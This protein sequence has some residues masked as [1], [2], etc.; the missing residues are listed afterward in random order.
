MHKMFGQD[1][2]S[3]R[4][5]NRAEMNSR[6]RLVHKRSQKGRNSVSPMEQDAPVSA[7]RDEIKI[8]VNT[9]AFLDT[10]RFDD[11]DAVR[12]PQDSIYSMG[13]ELAS[14]NTL[15]STSPTG[16]GLVRSA[17]PPDDDV[18][19]FSFQFSPPA[20]NDTVFSSSTE[21]STDSVRSM[22]ERLAVTTIFAKQVTVLMKRLTIGGSEK[23]PMPSPHRT[24]SDIATYR[25]G[26]PGPVPHPGLAVP[27]DFLVARRYV[28]PCHME[29]HF[30]RQL[31]ETSCTCWC[32]IADET[33]DDTHESFYITPDE[34]CCEYAAQFIRAGQASGVDHFGNTMLHLFA[35]L[36]TQSGIDTTLDLLETRQVNPVAVN[37][38]GQTFLHVLSAAWFAR[39]DDNA[40]PLYRVLSLLWEHRLFHALFMRDVYGRTF[41][42]QLDRFVDNVQDFR[43]VANHYTFGTIPRDAFGVL[44][45]TRP[46]E[47]SFPAPQRAGTTPLSPLVEED[48]TQDFDTTDQKLLRVLNEAYENHSVEDEQGRNGLQCLAE[49]R[50]DAPPSSS[51]TSPNPDRP[52]GG[53]GSKRKRGKD[54]ADKPK[55]IERRAQYLDGLLTPPPGQMLPDVNHYDKKGQ[56]VLMAFAVHL[57]DD[58]DKQGHH[59]AKIIDLLL[60]RGANIEARNR[61]GETAL[62][63]A[64]KHGNK[65]IVGK[66]LEKGANIHAR[67][68]KG[69]GIMGI[70]EWCIEQ[71]SRDLPSYG[72]LEAVRGMLAKKFEDTGAEDEPSL[73]HE[74]GQALKL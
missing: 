21:M 27:G 16:L 31:R 28:Q 54:D 72:R 47:F 23:H 37:Q 9:P 50:L 15:A 12:S 53:G 74:W 25:R 55:L 38:A 10:P 32:T 66:L 58:Q 35:A 7:F 4:P 59:V 70:L 46:G 60:D 11:L 68:V 56:T 26:H 34:E 6:F 19:P 14:P 29:K 51:P 17:F 24:P 43:R 39:M 3:L 2:R 69:R 5:A 48:N 33:S 52:A 42:H 40:A 41:F 57:T 65:H 63:I 71:S 73:W 30:A 22:R 1:P 13:S 64:A 49:V 18:N 61:R 36:E 20:R 8:E 62:L 67:D 45:P 44:P